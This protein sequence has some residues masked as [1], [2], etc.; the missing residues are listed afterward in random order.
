V[1]KNIVGRPSPPPPPNVPAVEPDIRGTT[2]IR[3]QLAKHRQIA[4]CAGCHNKIDPPG[5]ALECF[6]PIGNL[7]DYYRIMGDNGKRVDVHVK[8][9]HVRYKQGPAVDAS[10]EMPDGKRFKNIADFKRILLEDKDQIARCLTEKLLT[11]ATGGRIRPADG[12]IV[13]E[14]VAGVRDKNYGLRS[15]IHEVI[16]SPIFLNK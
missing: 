15:L 13:T 2:T 4:S 10:G 14:I 16:Q 1:L 7:R 11:Y 3:E 6:D 8:G 12:Q 9:A 5:F